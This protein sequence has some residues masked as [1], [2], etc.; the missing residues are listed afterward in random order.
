M[1]TADIAATLQQLFWA[2]PAF[3]VLLADVWRAQPRD[4]EAEPVM[5]FRSEGFAEDLVETHPCF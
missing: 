1:M 2:S 4:H 5:L 3:P